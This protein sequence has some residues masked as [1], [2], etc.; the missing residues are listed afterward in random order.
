MFGSG[1]QTLLKCLSFKVK[2]KK[3]PLYVIPASSS[4]ITYAGRPN[5]FFLPLGVFQ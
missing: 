1:R 5:H 4:T 2:I 3:N